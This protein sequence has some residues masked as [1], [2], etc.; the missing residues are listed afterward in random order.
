[1]YGHVLRLARTLPIHTHTSSFTF[2]LSVGGALMDKT[3][4]T[5]NLKHGRVQGRAGTSRAV[6]EVSTFDNLRLENQLTK[7]TSLVRQLAA[8]TSCVICVWNMHFSGAPYQH[9]TVTTESE[10]RAACSTTIWTSRGNA[11]FKSNQLSIART[12]IPG[13]RIPPTTATTFATPTK[14]FL[15]RRLSGTIG[16]HSEPNVV[17]QFRNYP[18]PDDSEFERGRSRHG[19]ARKRRASAKSRISWNRQLAKSVSLSFPNQA[20]SAKRSKIDEDLLKLFKKVE[21]NILLLDAIK[22]IPKYAKFLTEL[23]IHRRKKMKGTFEIGG[24]V[25]SLVQHE[26]TRARIQRILPKKCP[27]PGIFAVLYTIGKVYIH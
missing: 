4:T 1:M 16:Q 9:A 7:L 25:L 2:V 5:P 8:S 24:V 22:Q 11:G 14:F 26:D 19:A 15:I 12:K 23:Y 13:T 21:I 27:Y 18:L 10:S 17:G 3:L 6:S 20:V